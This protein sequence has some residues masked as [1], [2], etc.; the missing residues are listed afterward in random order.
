MGADEAKGGVLS[1]ERDKEDDDDP[2]SWF[3]ISSFGVERD[4]NT[5]GSAFCFDEVTVGEVVDLGVMLEVIEEDAETCD[6]DV[7]FTRSI[8]ILKAVIALRTL[9]KLSE[10]TGGLCWSAID[11]DEWEER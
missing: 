11:P 6:E 3:D 8:T 10:S 9:A 7:D 2:T 1:F 5:S 4:I